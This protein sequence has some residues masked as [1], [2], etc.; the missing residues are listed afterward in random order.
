MKNCSKFSVVGMTIFLTSCTLH[1]LSENMARDDTYKIVQK[2]RCEAKDAVKKVVVD[3]FLNSNS[4]L[5]RELGL[6]IEKDEILLSEINPRDKKSKY[7][8]L[9]K[10]LPQRARILFLRFADAA[11][12]FDFTF[13]ISENNNNMADLS[14]RNPFFGGLFS[15][16]IKGGHENKRQ[17]KR[18]FLIVNTFEELHTDE[19]LSN[20][21]CDK[22]VVNHQNLA[23]PITGNI[24]LAEVV[25]TF[26]RLSVH[27][28]LA[29]NPKLTGK[30]KP[31]DVASFADTLTFT[32]KVFGQADP[33]ITLSPMTAGF[34]LIEAKGTLA[35]DRQDIHEVIIALRLPATGPDQLLFGAIS[36][37]QAAVRSVQRQRVIRFQDRVNNLPPG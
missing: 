6:A 16:N 2:I 11:I 30:P 32:T 35:S 8:H 33:K 27:G 1:P 25:D 26:T 18:N 10:K 4:E 3:L 7:F 23:Y 14:F 28:G 17:N 29:G 13:T 12:A 21:A 9:F 15:L 5:G 34:E 31:D 36:P 24:G 19:F 37:K 20:E 22:V